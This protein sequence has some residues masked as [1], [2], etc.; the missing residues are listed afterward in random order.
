MTLIHLSLMRSGGDEAKSSLAL[1]PTSS[2]SNTEL[3]MVPTPEL[4]HLTREDLRLVYEPAEDTF[5][6]LDALEQ[7]FPPEESSSGSDSKT[8]SSASQL[9]SLTTLPIDR[10]NEQIAPLEMEQRRK[11]RLCVE[12]G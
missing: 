3:V 1:S 12:I 10:K 9:P 2:S 4:S 11:P 6:L 8:G 7:A 5:I